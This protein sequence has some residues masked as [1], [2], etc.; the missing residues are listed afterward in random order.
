VGDGKSGLFAFPSD[1]IRVFYLL[2]GTRAGSFLQGA[3][4]GEGEDFFLLARARTF[5]FEWEV[6]NILETNL[7]LGVRNEALILDAAGKSNRPLRDPQEAALHKILDFLGDLML[8]G[9][10]VRGEFVGIRSGHRL[11]QEMVELL[12]REVGR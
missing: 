4:F 5:A 7:G 1:A 6:K 9:Y 11:N 8:L 2:D 3:Q 12:R 10:R